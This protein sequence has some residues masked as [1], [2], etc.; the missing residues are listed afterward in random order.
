MPVVAGEKL[1]PP[2]EMA[3]SEVAPLEE[4]PSE[5]APSEE[6]PLEVPGSYF[7]S[8]VGLGTDA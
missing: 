8:Q 1:M 7:L 2:S 4:A 5:E 3:P 6:A